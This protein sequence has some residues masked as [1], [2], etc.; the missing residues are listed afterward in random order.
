MKRKSLSTVVFERLL[1]QIRSGKLGPGVQLP[2]ETELCEVHE[3]SRTVVREAVARLR[4]EGLVIPR[5]GKGVFVSEAPM[6]SY[7][8]PDQDL[9]A[10]PQTIALLELRLAVEVE[11]AGLCA[12]RR[13]AAE[14]A[15]IRAEMERVDANHPDLSKARVHYDYDFHL[16]I[17][18]ATRNPQILDFLT[19]LSGALV[20]RLQ[21]GYVLTDALKVDYFDRIHQ[22]HEAI[23]LAIE[24]QDETGARRAM[25]RHLLN[26][27]ERL[28][29]LAFA[30]GLAPD[31]SALPVALFSES[32]AP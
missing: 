17:A 7:S 16:A 11:A 32:P 20:P 10:L 27:L 18:R 1:E 30:K 6:S 8:I 28:R 21:L 13:T 31:P 19:Y 24:S 22:E 14:A 5:Q 3:V 12:L 29:A 23:V 15:N 26:S 9:R 2:T 25:R 4:S